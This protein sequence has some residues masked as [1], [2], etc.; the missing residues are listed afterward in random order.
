[1]RGGGGRTHLYGSSF[2]DQ[3]IVG[4]V[5]VAVAFLT[6]R[7]TATTPVIVIVIVIAVVRER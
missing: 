1:M 7:T 2:K 5:A 3:R 6:E 4:V